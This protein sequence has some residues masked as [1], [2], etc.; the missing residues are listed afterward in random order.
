[1]INSTYHD[2]YSKKLLLYSLCCFYIYDFKIFFQERLANHFF[3]LFYL[4][5]LGVGVM[6]A[7]YA[8]GAAHPPLHALT[9][10]STGFVCLLEF[11]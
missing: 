2:V 10:H 6:S 9:L 5:H 1:M 7:L 11:A 4:L 3:D 8:L